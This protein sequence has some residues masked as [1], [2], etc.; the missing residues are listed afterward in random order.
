MDGG[1]SAIEEEVG[2]IEEE[3]EEDEDEEEE[4][5]E[6]EVDAAPG[7]VGVGAGVAGATEDT[8]LETRMGTMRFLPSGVVVEVDAGAVG[9][10][11]VAGGAGV[12]FAGGAVAAFVVNE[13][14]ETGLDDDV[15]AAEDE[16]RG[17][18]EDEDEDEGVWREAEGGLEPVTAV[19][20]EVAVLGADEDDEDDEDDEEDGW[21]EED[22]EDGWDEEEDEE[23]EACEVEGAWEGAVWGK[24][25]LLVEVDNERGGEARAE[26]EEEEEEATSE[27]AIFEERNPVGFGFGGCA[28]G[29][30][31]GC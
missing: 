6:E 30:C 24:G 18:E 5:E 20:A 29:G 15:A 1:C 16:G 3:E 13:E 26:E 23:E 17:E 31:A 28:G 11:G 12:R 10:A 8:V 2:G 27:S 7:R 22:K 4:E 19:G 25:A 21:D 14:D 9:A